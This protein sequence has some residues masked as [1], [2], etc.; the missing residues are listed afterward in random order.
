MMSVD[1]TQT[2]QGFSGGLSVGVREAKASGGDESG[3]HV[4]VAGALSHEDHHVTP[5][6][7]PGVVLSVDIPRWVHNPDAFQAE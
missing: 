2:S 1:H 7:A 3:F 5:K 4:R 6:G